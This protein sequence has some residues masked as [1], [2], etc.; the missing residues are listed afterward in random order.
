MQRLKTFYNLGP[1]LGRRFLS[2]ITGDLQQDSRER[3]LE[4]RN[5]NPTVQ[6]VR[7]FVEDVL[8]LAIARMLSEGFGTV[9]NEAPLMPHSE[10]PRQIE[11]L[12]TTQ[13]TSQQ[14]DDGLKCSVCLREY[15]LEETVCQTECKHYFHADCLACWIERKPTC[16]MCRQSI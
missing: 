1:Q 14:V 11:Q 8:G 13:I 10:I 3:T 16:P 4:A 5:V 12:P 6:N 2:N 15:D 7:P 9:D